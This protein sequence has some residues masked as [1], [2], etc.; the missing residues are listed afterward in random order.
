MRAA[1]KP[2]LL[3]SSDSEEEVVDIKVGNGFHLDWEPIKVLGATRR[4]SDRRLLILIAWK[5]RHSTF[6]YSEIANQLIPHL[7]I[8]YYEKKIRWK[9]NLNL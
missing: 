2:R 1:L 7:V 3:S 9:L 8:N 4:Q 6:E 5:G